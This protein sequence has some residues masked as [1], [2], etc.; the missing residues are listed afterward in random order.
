MGADELLGFRKF[1]SSAECCVSSL[2]LSTRDATIR[3][4]RSIHAI[5]EAK[6]FGAKDRV[7]YLLT[8][9][10]LFFTVPPRLVNIVDPRSVI[11]GR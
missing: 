2:V 8:I 4:Q 1:H 9:L 7:N 6:D 3:V 11:H 10:L 5:T